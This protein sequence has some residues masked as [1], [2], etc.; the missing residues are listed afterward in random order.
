MHT[1]VELRDGVLTTQ[2]VAEQD[3]D[4][5]ERRWRA[6]IRPAIALLRSLGGGG[7][8]VLHRPNELTP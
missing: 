5:S 2:I 3:C 4:V 7:L 1:M 6:S 8:M